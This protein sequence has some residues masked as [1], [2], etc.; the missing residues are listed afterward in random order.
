M[1]APPLFLDVDATHATRSVRQLFSQLDDELLAL[2]TPLRSLRE[3]DAQALG[4]ARTAATFT[5]LW[6]ANERA[7]RALLPHDVRPTLALADPSRAENSTLYPPHATAPRAAYGG[8]AQVIAHLARDWGAAGSDSRRRT[9]RPVLSAL[10]G[11]RR[12][13]R[14]LVPGAGACR[15][16][17]EIARVGFRVEANDAAT[18][19]LLAGRSIMSW[20]GDSMPVYP[21]I[22][23]EGGA[24]RRSSC[25]AGVMVPDV[26]PSRARTTQLTLQAGDFL[27]TYGA[28][29]HRLAWDA[30][31]TCY[32]IDTLSD[33]VAAVR[34]IHD[35]LVPGGKWINIG[36][37]QW[38]DH[39]AGLLRLSYD[40][41]TA[42][43]VRQGFVIEQTRRL[44]KIPYLRASRD[45]LASSSR[46]W[47]DCVFFV[48]RKASDTETVP[49]YQKI[50]RSVRSYV[51]RGV[52]S[53]DLNST[54]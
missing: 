21:Q 38:H 53:P 2:T 10:R 24:M 46:N 5:A 11:L 40:E 32:F 41:L 50:L 3:E 13:A 31:V 34:C 43:L 29:G 8:G 33:P 17:W 20:R 16:A 19:M 39:T 35:L 30:V 14:V 48:A 51:S 52:P 26:S 22:R 44:T 45:L 25:H 18:P 15:L 47:H 6:E 28:S 42:L 37:L 36:P 7:L 4:I 49:A 27:R 12:P 1:A 9:H 23:C 54:T